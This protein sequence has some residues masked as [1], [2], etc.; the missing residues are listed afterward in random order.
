MKHHILIFF[1][2][3]AVGFGAG[4]INGLLGAGGGILIVFALGRLFRGKLRDPRSIYATAVAV[5]LPLSLLSAWQYLSHK[6]FD[7]AL[8]AALILPAIVGGAAGALLLRRL[9]PALLSRIFAAVVLISGI[10]MVL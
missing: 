8:A 9:S 5:I 7:P 2:L 1:T 6:S 4:T 10:T 3:L